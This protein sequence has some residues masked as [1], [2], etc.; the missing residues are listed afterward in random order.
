[1][2][3]MNVKYSLFIFSDC[4]SMS[5]TSHLKHVTM[6]VTSMTYGRP[7]TILLPVEQ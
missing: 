6:E 4:C 1:M 5:V 7:M 3:A 2:N